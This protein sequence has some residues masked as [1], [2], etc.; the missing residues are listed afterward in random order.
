MKTSTNLA[1]SFPPN[2][3]L[4]MPVRLRLSRSHL[5]RNSPS[6]TLVAQPSTS[7]PTAQPL[8]LLG[9][10]TPLPTPINP[11]PLSPNGQARET[12]IWGPGMRN[13]NEGTEKRVRWNEERVKWWLSLGAKPSKTVERLLNQAGIISKLSL[14]GAREEKERC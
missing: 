4:V 6:Y 11:V 13:G 5:T 10:Y 8:E 2:N 1:L 12:S 3:P 7:R 14:F 9:Y